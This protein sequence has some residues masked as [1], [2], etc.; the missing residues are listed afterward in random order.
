MSLEQQFILNWQTDNLE[1]TPF[2]WDSWSKPLIVVN[3]LKARI[4]IIIHIKSKAFYS[5]CS[6]LIMV[7]W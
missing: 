4:K 1:N 6:R 2:Q 3:R 5:K 7:H